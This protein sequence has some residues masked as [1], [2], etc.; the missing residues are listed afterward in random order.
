MQS[1]IVIC[2]QLYMFGGNIKVMFDAILPI[3]PP[4]TVAESVKEKNKQTPP[5]NVKTVSEQVKGVTQQGV[6]TIL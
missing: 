2:I 5:K 4:F 3:G 6:Y 1:S